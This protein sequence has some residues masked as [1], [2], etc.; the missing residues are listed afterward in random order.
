M[1]Q[2][3]NVA[4]PRLR[5]TFIVVAI[6]A[7]ALWSWS[8]VLAVE[9]TRDPHGDGFDLLPAFWTTILLLPIAIVTLIGGI[10]G[11]GKHAARAQ[12]ALIIAGGLVVLA[13]LL[14]IFR[15]LSMAIP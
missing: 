10:A 11:H 1:E 15:R 9:A 2:S 12:M 3:P 5:A 4:S 14:E 6:C 13:A 8:L 7:F